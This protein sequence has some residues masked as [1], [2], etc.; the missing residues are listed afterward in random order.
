MEAIHA[1]FND[2]VV[3]ATEE[4]VKRKETDHDIWK[5]TEGLWHSHPVFGKKNIKEAIEFLRGKD[6]DV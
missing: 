5:R 2:R 3:F 6:S 4:L 1:K